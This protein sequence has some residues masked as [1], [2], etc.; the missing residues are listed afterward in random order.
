MP[1][2]MEL[3]DWVRLGLVL[4]RCGWIVDESGLL[5]L[6]ATCASGRT[7]VEA[8]SL[9]DEWVAQQLEGAGRGVG[10]G[11]CVECGWRRGAGHV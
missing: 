1:S 9:S 4:R 5:A 7:L 10:V 11:L 3:A 8:L 2:L 6:R